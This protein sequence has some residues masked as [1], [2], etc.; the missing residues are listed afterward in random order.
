MR[1]CNMGKIT[2]LVLA[3]ILMITMIP[4]SVFSA[5]TGQSEDI[6][7]LFSSDVHGKPEDN[8]GYAGLKAYENEVKKENRYVSVVDGGD[9]IGGSMLSAVS[10]GKYSVESMNLAGYAVAVPGVHDFDHGVEQLRGTLAPLAEFDY[11]S[12]NFIRTSDNQAVFSPFKLEVYGSKMVAYVGISDPLTASKSS[13]DFGTAYDFCSGGNGAELYYRVQ[14]AVD[15]A[16]AFG[17]EYVIAVAHL[18]DDASS[19]YSAQS[20]IKNTEG[21]TAV[22]QGGTHSAFA[23]QSIKDSGGNTVLLS[24]AGSGLKNIGVLTIKTNET[25]EAKLIGNYNLRD[26]KVQDGIKTLQA[27]YNS[28]L[29]KDFAATTSRLEAVSTSGTRVV[30]KGETNLGDL[31]ADAYREATGADVALVESRE[32]RGSLALG[33]I[34]YKDVLQV[35]PEGK[36]IGVAAVSG[37]DLMDAL[38]MSARLYPNSNGGFFQISGLTYDIQE[39]VIPSVSLDGFGNFRGISGQYRVTNVMVNGAELDLFATY[40][41]AGTEE[42]LS[43]STGYTMF[44]NGTML[45]T[46]VTSDNLAVIAYLTDNLKGTAGGRYAKSQGRVDS[47][48]L[49]RQSELDQEVADLVKNQLKEYEDKI[50]QLEKQLKQKTEILAIKDMEITASSKYGKSSGKRYITVTWKCSEKVDG[51]KY[52]LYK[53]SKKSSGFSKMKTTTSLSYKNTSGLT[54]GKTYY[55]KVRGYKSIGGK[56]Y[57]TDWSNTVSRKVTS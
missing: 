41:V 26:V 19:P 50:A 21:L 13:A 35:L 54:K 37:A 51:L 43:G 2:S 48:K 15:M 34:S 31:T 7:I 39:T 11:V 40:K 47:I 16:R 32:L 27:K 22:I 10:K 30:D 45:Q 14:N 28:S 4:T 9:S 17:A 53:S 24:S 20:V 23:G 8:L 44:K 38:E 49:L 55:Y 18:S 57:Y 25:L 1:K 52:Q 36:P 29:T 12:C 56:T 42:L 5:E 3:C 6:V 33:S 46:G